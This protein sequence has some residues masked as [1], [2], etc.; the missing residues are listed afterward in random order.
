MTEPLVK[1]HSSQLPS[2]RSEI[3]TKIAARLSRLPLFTLRR[4]EAIFIARARIASATSL[5]VSGI[6]SVEYAWRISLI[7]SI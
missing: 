7:A 1:L 6:F 3:G 4:S 2:G 5:M